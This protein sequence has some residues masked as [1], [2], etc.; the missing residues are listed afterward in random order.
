MFF[1]RLDIFFQGDA[2]G[3]PKPEHD[4]NLRDQIRSF[5]SPDAVSN[6]AE[7]WQVNKIWVF[8]T[9][10]SVHGFKEAL[11]MFTQ[12]I[13]SQNTMA[14]SYVEWNILSSWQNGSLLSL[15]FTGMVEHNGSGPVISYSVII[16]QSDLIMPRWVIIIW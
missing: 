14:F 10:I 5:Q 4:L 11:E 12:N 16:Q 6:V 7:D 3:V 1:L 9:S 15:I 8:I 2:T 13:G